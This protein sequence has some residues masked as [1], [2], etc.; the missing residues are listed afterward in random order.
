MFCSPFYLNV[1]LAG[2]CHKAILFGACP[3]HA[4]YT[5]EAILH[6]R[7]QT[8]Q[9]DFLQVTHRFEQ[10][11]SPFTSGSGST[12]H[13]SPGVDG[14]S[15]GGVPALRSLHGH[16]L[17]GYGQLLQLRRQ[18]RAANRNAQCVQHKCLYNV[19]RTG[20]LTGCQSGGQQAQWSAFD[21]RTQHNA[22]AGGDCVFAFTNAF[23]WSSTAGGWSKRLH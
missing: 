22:S 3:N 8:D 16:W 10:I 9:A 7:Q 14:H 13:L 21:Q 19:F 12:A 1:S 17:H 18:L 6:D 23:H 20:P 11:R 4:L 5:A 15:L 2:I